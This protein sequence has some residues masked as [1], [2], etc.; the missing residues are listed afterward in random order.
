MSYFRRLRAACR[1]FWQRRWDRWI[2]KRIPVSDRFTLGMQSIFIVPSGFGW[3][4]LV[5]CGLIFLSAIN[6]QNNSLY[7]FC[8]VLISIF[9]VAIHISYRYMAGM[10]IELYGEIEGFADAPIDYR[11]LIA[12]D[13]LP[14]R[15]AISVRGGDTI[16]HEVNAGSVVVAGT[17]AAAERGY[18]KIPRIR[19]SS[20][21]PFGLFRCWTWLGLQ[22]Q[23]CCFPVPSEGVLDA[24]DSS[25]R[26]ATPFMQPARDSE[27]AVPYQQGDSLRYVLWR[28]WARSE[29]LLV[30]REFIGATGERVF[31][32]EL[33]PLGR[34]DKELMLSGWS[35]SMIEL[36][37]Q[38][39]AFC[40]Y[41]SSGEKLGPDVGAVHLRRC[42]RRLAA[43][44]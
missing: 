6:Y 2:D 25:S 37:D 15:I 41:L 40:L 21:F 30:S 3:T 35:K 29:K 44:T 34:R 22:T 28:Q 33:L 17:L 42:L 43:I 38:Q 23:M 7:G 13:N 11:L 24:M 12:G 8:F 9:V 19:L 14:A 1:Q 36:C 16:W 4:Y 32:E 20:V 27:M 31:D 26:R 39:M 18:H 10:T 5:V